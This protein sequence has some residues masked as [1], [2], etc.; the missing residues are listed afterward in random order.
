MECRMWEKCEKK[1]LSAWVVGPECHFCSADRYSGRDGIAFWSTF[2]S[3]TAEPLCFTQTPYTADSGSIRISDPYWVSTYARPFFLAERAAVTDDTS[4]SA[5]T[6]TGAGASGPSTRSTSQVV[7]TTAGDGRPTDTGAGSAGGDGQ[8]AT[9]SG[10]SAGAIA[11]IIIAVVL[12]ILLGVGAFIFWRRRRLLGKHMSMQGGSKGKEMDPPVPPPA[13]N[14]IES[15][16][17][18][19]NDWPSESESPISAGRGL[20][21]VLENGGYGYKL[22]IAGSETALNGKAYGAG[23]NHERRVSA[24]ENAEKVPGENANEELKFKFGGPFR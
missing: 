14:G 13:G 12:P 18:P 19:W 23:E 21:G 1:L 2:G 16:V 22:P 9:K 3:P 10:L 11:G 6:N 20:P 17:F 4:T 7:G 5:P 15:G 24:F 8:Q